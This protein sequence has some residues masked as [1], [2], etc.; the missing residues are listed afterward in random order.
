MTDTTD[1]TA[2][3]TDP[4][5]TADPA[6]GVPTACPLPQ[7]RRDPAPLRPYQREAVTAIVRGLAAGGPGQWHAC[8]GSGKTLVAQRAAEQFLG[9]AGTV[10][11]LAPS[12]SLVAQ[13]LA[14]WQHH[15]RTGPIR[16]LAVCSD[17]TVADA[18]THLADLT[19]P[20]T[21]DPAQIAAW[22][23]TP[24]ATGLRLIVGT[25][26]SADRLAEAVR[27]TTPLDLLVLDEA[28]HL[29][30]RADQTTRRCVDRTHLPARRSLYL[31]ATPRL[32]NL[33]DTAP[34]L[35]M[36][37][38]T[39][40]GPV[41]HSY[42]AAR[43]IAEGYLE[44]YRIAVIGIPDRDA[45][46]LLTDPAAE[47]IDRPGAPALQTVV[48]QA[49][50]IK[51]RERYG[52][53][54]AL[55]F[56][57]RVDAAA[58]FARTLPATVARLGQD[59]EALDAGHVHGEMPHQQRHRILTRLAAVPDGRWAAVASARCLAE[60]VDVP[61]VDAVLFA[62]PK[63]SAVDIVQ[64][65][66]RAL[67]RHP[68][69]DGPSTIIV[70][71]VVPDTDGEIGDLDAGAYQTLW[72]VIRA[73]RAH[74]E[75][76]GVALDRQRSHASTSNPRLPGKISI[77]LPEGTSQHVID[78][79]TVLTVRQT[80][81]PWWEQHARAAAW[82]AEHGHLDIPLR[83]AS[84]DG[85][86]LGQWL[87]QQRRFYRKGWLPADRITALEALG[88]V[89]DPADARW[90]QLLTAY[91]TW[92]QQHGHLDIPQ[93]TTAPGPDGTVLQLG[94][95]IIKQRAAHRQGALAP[96]RVAALEEAGIAW[97]PYEAAW[98]RNVQAWLDH[99]AAHDGADV[100]QRHVT[101][102][103]LR[104]GAWVSQMRAKRANGKLPA[105]RAAELDALGFPWKGTPRWEPFLAAA[106]T[107][108]QQHG[109]LNPPPGTTVN[110]LDLT[111]WLTRQRATHQAGTLHPDLAAQLD[112]LGID[113]T[114]PEPADPFTTG[115]AAARTYRAQHGHLRPPHNTVHDGVQLSAWLIRQ[116]KH[117]RAGTL[118]PERTAQLDALG[119][120][121]DPDADDWQRLLAAVRAFHTCH[122]HLR[123]PTGTVVDGV[124]LS[125]ALIRARKRWRLGRLGPQQIRDL[126][127]LGMQWEVP[128]GRVRP[129]PGT[130]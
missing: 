26:A 61:A 103:G 35:S 10:A 39:V 12:L 68:D 82:H 18:A 84:A 119:M 100:P 80:T 66:G 112:A 124:Q 75:P 63:R 105:H 44:D 97:D 109:H 16:V 40:F 83:H 60:G 71:L 8:C 57:H 46:A 91:R 43:G 111:T 125:N 65:V 34:L 59:P 95:W 90:Q 72:Q 11:V 33:Q 22:L 129:A 118:T 89:W 128:K 13:T 24:T 21:T 74:D 98:Q 76:L 7:P 30:G 38:T 87:V 56:H 96:E 2:D 104:L 67:R 117:H 114:P 50:L 36:S 54:R 19:C 64:A 86:Q 17:D 130:P 70:P 122:G 58:E 116:R 48:A 92:R 51:A 28:H 20:V 15:T 29:T 6:A 102:D 9:P 120:V 88:V 113:W 110:G 81:S 121:W 77:V 23:H 52:L 42:P 4:T 126:D 85:A 69:T 93:H 25:Y 55:T 115:L 123:P 78:Q 37:D 73:L 101:A 5:G 99:R 79:L 27:A 32:E 1:T 53:R 41:L 108:H 45:R 106:R 31:T 94:G 62:H 49:A 3:T 107:Y 14:S 47:Y 127:A